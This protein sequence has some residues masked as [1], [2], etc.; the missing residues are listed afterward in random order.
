MAIRNYD[1]EIF[2]SCLF[3]HIVGP[4]MLFTHDNNVVQAFLYVN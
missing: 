1:F 2:S 3:T 4:T